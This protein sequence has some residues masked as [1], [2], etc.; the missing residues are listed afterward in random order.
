MANS[1]L[2]KTNGKSG[3]AVACDLASEINAEHQACMQAAGK[4]IEHAMRC[5]DLLS[6][7]KAKCPYGE[8]QDW[9]K[10]NFDAS[11]RTAR[12]YMR[13]AENRQMIESKRQSVA[14]LGVADA[15][16]LIA[17]PRLDRCYPRRSDDPGLVIND[18]PAYDRM[19]E[20]HIGYM[21][22]AINYTTEAMALLCHRTNAD[23]SA[24][25]DYERELTHIVNGWMR[26][27]LKMQALLG[28]VRGQDFD[29][30]EQDGAT[31]QGYETELRA[32]N[33]RFG[34]LKARNTTAAEPLRQL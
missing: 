12:A 32:L 10:Q 33:E 23:L 11:S 17:A 7:A 21:R 18:P 19:R 5:G 4:A 3:T 9:L 34:E 6:E 26:Y 27:R 16:R 14:T 30:P 13:L 1:T 24:I 22:N 28:E 15:I 20:R 8:W 29:Y 2:S 25:C 31:E